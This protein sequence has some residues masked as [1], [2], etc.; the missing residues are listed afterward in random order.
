MGLNTSLIKTEASTAPNA[1][2]NALRTEVEVVQQT[3]QF[4]V[5]IK[6]FRGERGSIADEG[7]T[8]QKFSKINTYGASL[9]ATCTC[10]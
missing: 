7:Y 9:T 5:G 4:K 1:T 10:L 3:V 2:G 6:N 8:C